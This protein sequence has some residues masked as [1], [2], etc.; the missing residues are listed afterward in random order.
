M[1]SYLP[2]TP[3]SDVTVDRGRRRIDRTSIT[4]TLA[5]SRALTSG[6][7]STAVPGICVPNYWRSVT[8]YCKFRYTYY[9]AFA[10]PTGIAISVSICLFLYICLSVCW[11][12]YDSNFHKIF[13]YMLPEAVARS[14]SD[15]NTTIDGMKWR[16]SNL[17]CLCCRASCRSLRS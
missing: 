17:Q 8:D 11:L 7:Y 3:G 6:N 13:P 5:A 1:S 14:S 12:S 10:P 15:D 4:R 16:H 2:Y 9:F